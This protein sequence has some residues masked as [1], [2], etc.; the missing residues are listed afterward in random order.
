MRGVL[1][2]PR[3]IL[4]VVVIVLA[5]VLIFVGELA[6]LK[7]LG[8][9]TNGSTLAFLLGF[10][11]ATFLCAV[12]SIAIVFTGATSYLTGGLAERWTRQ[13]FAAL[14]PAWHIF[15]NVPFSVGFGEVAYT[16]DVDHIVVGPYGVLVLE[17]KFSSSPLDLG[18]VQ[19]EKRVS[20]AMVQVEDNA[21][22]ARALLRQVVP[23]VPIR[24]VIIFWGRLVKSP[25]SSVRRVE[26]RAEDVRIVHGGKAREWRPKLTERTVL[27]PETVERVSARIKNYMA[28]MKRKSRTDHSPES[29]K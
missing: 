28:D 7:A 21:G 12:L 18:A 25:P 4:M 2:A 9:R 10:I 1:F 14:G 13:E 3:I 24:P 15:S 17:T 11:I 27:P 16:I 29:D 26:G 20:E 6:A 22:R 8:I 23:D 19:L 5:Y